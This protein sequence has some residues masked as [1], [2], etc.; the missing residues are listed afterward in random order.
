MKKLNV[1]IIGLGVG[2][3]HLEAYLKLKNIGSISVYDF[4]KKKM[5]CMKCQTKRY[6]W[7]P[8]FSD[9]ILSIRYEKQKLKDVPIFSCIFEVF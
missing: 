5:R 1:G 9:S 8:I 3:R 4:D 6:L 7:C 2:Q